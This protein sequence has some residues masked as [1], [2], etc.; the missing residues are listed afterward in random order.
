MGSSGVEWGRVGS[1]GVEWG[2]VGS[3]GVEWGRECEW[4]AWKWSVPLRRTDRPRFLR[5]HHRPIL[6]ALR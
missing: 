6:S 2:R 4:G 3:S 1:S 5:P